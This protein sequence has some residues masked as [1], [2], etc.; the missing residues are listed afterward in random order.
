MEEFRQAVEVLRELGLSDYEARAYAALLSMGEMSPREVS[1]AA[2]IPYTKVYE[3]L[4]RLEG[5][6]WIARVSSAPLVYAP[7]EPEDVIAGLK[8]S[9]ESKLLRAADVL[10]ALKIGSLPAPAGVYIIRSFESLKQTVKRIT[11]EAEEA[12]LVIYDGELLKALQQ[13]LSKCKSVRGILGSEIQLPKFGEW[14]QAQVMLPL[15]MLIT[16]RKKLVLSFGPFSVQWQLSGLIVLDEEVASIA[17]SYFEKLWISAPPV[18]CA[19]GKDAHDAG[20]RAV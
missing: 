3:V 15:D 19:G 18:P 14:K 16:D 12:L 6:G 17:A 9:L 10:R 1:E 11:A 2:N 5:R 4:R 13:P 8:T 20:W 7:R